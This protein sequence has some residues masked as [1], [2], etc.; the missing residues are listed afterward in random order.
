MR[1]RV[2]V[3]F[4][5]ACGVLAAW[6]TGWWIGAWVLDRADVPWT[7]SLSATGITLPLALALAALVLV[8]HGMKRNVAL[9]ADAA[10]EAETRLRL[11]ASQLTASGA[12]GDGPVLLQRTA[13][14]SASGAT[15][16]PSPATTVG[17]ATAPAPDGPAAAQETAELPAARSGRRSPLVDKGQRRAK[18]LAK[19]ELRRSFRN[20]R[21]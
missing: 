6:P 19:R 11:L 20:L 18:S 1:T 12:V 15:I 17:V 4:L 5:A 13:S 7:A 16:A 21:S 3:S 10:E 9:Q 14:V 8:V 2:L